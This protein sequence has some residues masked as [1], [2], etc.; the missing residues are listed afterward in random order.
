MARKILATTSLLAL[1]IGG[2]AVAEQLSGNLLTTLPA[3]ASTVTNYYKQNVYDPSDN[4]IGEVTD[5]LVQKDGKIPAVMI[6]VGGFLGMGEKD[7]AVA[8]DALQPTTK[9]DKVHLVM[10]TT[11]DALKSAS[12]FKY[13]RNTG[14]WIPESS[15]KTQ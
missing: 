4:K 7:V 10:N 12:G 8:F 14:K 11:K 13:D 2:A 1:L 6:A 9:N 3:D 15:A 5:L